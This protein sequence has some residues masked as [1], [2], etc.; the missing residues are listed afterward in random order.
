VTDDGSSRAAVGAPRKRI[1]TERRERPFRAGIALCVIGLVV[2]LTGGAV[3]YGQQATEILAAEGRAEIPGDITFEA[4]TGTYAIV[5]LREL[6]GFESIERLV[7]KTVCTV[8]LSDETVLEISGARQNGSLETDL[9][10]S[11]GRFDAETGPTTVSC[12]FG[13]SVVRTGYFVSV[14]PETSSIRIVSYVLMGLGLLSMAAGVVL[15]IVG[16]RGRMVVVE[17]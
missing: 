1:T 14:A 9:G 2:L 3:A 4:E 12:G 8:T 10:T 5:L 7:P 13:D 16:V 17:A 11:L 15:I 6:P